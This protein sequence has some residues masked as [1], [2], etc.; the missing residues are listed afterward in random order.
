MPHPP[1]TLAVRAQLPSQLRPS[2]SPDEWAGRGTTAA[3]LRAAVLAV[4]LPMTPSAAMQA[5]A[6]NFAQVADWLFPTGLCPL[7]S[8][9]I[10]KHCPRKAFDLIAGGNWFLFLSKIHR[11]ER[12][13]LQ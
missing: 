2:S 7:A 11:R 8:F 1:W 3:P 13:K 5:T 9:T 6:W 12:A 10:R 4:L